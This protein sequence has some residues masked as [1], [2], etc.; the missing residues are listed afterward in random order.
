[1]R[2]YSVDVLSRNR[3]GGVLELQEL[4]HRDDPMAAVR[5]ACCPCFESHIGR[6]APSVAQ[7]ALHLAPAGR[8][9]MQ[10]VFW[11]HRVQSALKLNGDALEASAIRRDAELQLASRVVMLETRGQVFERWKPVPLIAELFSAQGEFHV[12]VH[13]HACRDRRQRFGSH[14]QNPY[15]WSCQRFNTR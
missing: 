13:R 11:W 6:I 15:G 10:T 2:A 12:E 1:M 8:I 9:Q 4:H 5:Q 7:V 3:E 14:S